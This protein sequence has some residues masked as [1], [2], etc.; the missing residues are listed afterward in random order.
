MRGDALRRQYLYQN[1]FEVYFN[2]ATIG[3]RT[4]TK[5]HHEEERPQCVG[6]AIHH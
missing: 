4:K 5:N 1:R 3:R 2:A 6:R